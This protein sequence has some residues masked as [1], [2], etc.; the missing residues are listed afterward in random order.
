[1]SLPKL[2]ELTSNY[3]S[4]WDMVNDDD[5]DMDAL[6]GTMQS[7]EAAIEIKAQNIAVVLDSLKGYTNTLEDK[8]GRLEARK[9]AFNNR[10]DHIKNYLKQQLEFAGIEKVVTAEYTISLQS[11][12]G[13]VVVDNGIEVPSA[14]L[15]VIPE[16]YKVDKKR[17]AADIRAGKVIPGIRLESGKSLRIR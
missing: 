4:V 7:I 17:I 1:M 5:C 9:Q 12:P 2:S 6:E 14:Y 3:Q 13:S 15:T 8:I 10:I 11:N 16:S